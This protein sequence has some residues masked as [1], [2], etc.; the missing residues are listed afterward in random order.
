[1]D[2]LLTR[3]HNPESLKEA[4]ASDRVRGNKACLKAV[5]E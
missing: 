4:K 1:M 5:G 3:L 2:D